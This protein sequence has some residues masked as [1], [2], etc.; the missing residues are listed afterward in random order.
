MWRQG[1]KEG[2]GGGC[3]DKVGRR[4]EDVETR[5]EGGREDV[6]TRWEGGGGCGD[7]VGRRGR[8]RRQGGKEEGGCGDKVGGRGEDKETRWHCGG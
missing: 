2:G 7:K 3:G 5:W 4:G 1:G 8:I 6:E